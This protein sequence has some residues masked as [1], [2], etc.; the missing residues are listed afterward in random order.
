MTTDAIVFIFC[1]I[2]GAF[3]LGLEIGKQHQPM[4]C[5]VVPGAEVVSTIAPDTCV[6]ASNYGRALRKVKAVRS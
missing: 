1:Y 3:V 4:T 6:Y 5:P 2:A